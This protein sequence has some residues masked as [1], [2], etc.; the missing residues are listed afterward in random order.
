MSQLVCPPGL[1]LLKRHMLRPPVACRPPMFHPIVS[2]PAPPKVP[3]PSWRGYRAWRLSPAAT[4]NPPSGKAHLDKHT[5]QHDLCGRGL[6][7]IHPLI[8]RMHCFAMA[9]TIMSGWH[10]A[11]SAF[12]MNGSPQSASLRVQ[13][14]RRMVRQDRSLTYRKG[15]IDA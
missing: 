15:G 11:V 10:G 12:F 7:K 6:P 14:G 9:I 2:L 4:P 8:V 13:R 1:P 3:G 5:R